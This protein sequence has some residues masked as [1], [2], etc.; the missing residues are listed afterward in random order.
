MLEKLELVPWDSIPQPEWNR[1]GDVAAAIGA[2]VAA[3]SDSDSWDAYNRLLFATGNNHAGTYYPVV[4][5]VIPFLGE[6]LQDGPLL[7]RLRALDA[8][9]DLVGCFCPEPGYENVPSMEGTA[10]P[11][12]AKM[13]SA[14]MRMWSEVGPAVSSRATDARELDLVEQTA[15]LLTED[16]LPVSGTGGLR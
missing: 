8:L 14:V 15:T 6:I 11:L 5:E 2:L 4:L 16:A 1:R 13:R 3:S 7:A 10:T 12:D 9:I